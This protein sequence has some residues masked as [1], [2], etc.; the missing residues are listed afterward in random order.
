MTT[1]DS[2]AGGLVDVTRL[3][4]RGHRE[5]RPTLS[6]Q[7]G[8]IEAVTR[9]GA[10][11]GRSESRPGPRSPAV[12][13]GCDNAAVRNPRS[14][15]LKARALESECRR[16]R[17]ASRELAKRPGGMRSKFRIKLLVEPHDA[18]IFRNPTYIEPHETGPTGARIDH[19]RPI[20]SQSS[21]CFRAG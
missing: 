16:S 18:V 15:C 2:S 5:R 17:A 13:L 19:A 7:V 3:F 8:R 11:G 9:T 10:A 12:A 1:P 21:S 20:N 4:G 14:V 6:G